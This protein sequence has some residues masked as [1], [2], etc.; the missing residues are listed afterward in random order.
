MDREISIE[1][2]ELRAGTYY[3][4]RRTGGTETEIVLVTDIFG[5]DREYWSVA[6]MGTDQHHSLREFKFLIRLM[7]P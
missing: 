6:T 4:A 1:E 2:G 5:S 3:W 7:R